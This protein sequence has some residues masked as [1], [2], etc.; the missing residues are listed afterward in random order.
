[1]TPP[2]GVPRSLGR[3]GGRWRKAHAACRAQ[4]ARGA[5]CALCGERIDVT[6]AYPHPMSFAADHD[7]ELS[8]GGLPYSIRPSHKACNEAKELA[9]RRALANHPVERAS[10]A[11]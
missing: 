3:T 1:M 9:R 7:V 10:R 6:I 11:W 4:A 8:D 2:R 5:P